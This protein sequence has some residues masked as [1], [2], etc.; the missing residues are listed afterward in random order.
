[1]SDILVQINNI[2]IFD[3]PDA[4]EGLHEGGTDAY[5]VF[6]VNLPRGVYS[7]K[8]KIMM[9]GSRTVRFPDEVRILLKGPLK[10]G[11]LEGAKMIVTCWD[12]DEADADDPMG[13][14]VERLDKD[15]DVRENAPRRTLTG[16]GKFH[17]FE[18]LFNYTLTPWGSGTLV[19]CR[20][21]LPGEGTEEAKNLKVSGQRGLTITRLPW[22]GYTCGAAFASSSPTLSGF[23]EAIVSF[24][25][26]NRDGGRHMYVGIV[27]AS[28]MASV[29]ADAYE[30][31]SVKATASSVTSTKQKAGS[32]PGHVVLLNLYSG[33]CF[34]GTTYHVPSQILS[35][36]LDK[37]SLKELEPE[38]LAGC[39]L[40]RMRVDM[41]ERRVYFAV[42]DRPWVDSGG[43]LGAVCR[44]CAILGD[45]EGTV[46]TLGQSALFTEREKPK[47]EGW[48]KK[49]NLVTA[50]ANLP[51]EQVTKIIL[52]E[53][54][55]EDAPGIAEECLFF[56]VDWLAKKELQEREK[57]R[58]EQEELEMRKA[59]KQGAAAA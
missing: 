59:A 8:T 33:R 12:Y 1:M 58:R 28:D 36:Q 9:D 48:N 21:A 53:V 19:A 57:A 29:A 35:G 27:I 4:D 5:V 6:E 51:A 42:G 44:P 16:I 40:I 43:K 10:L 15:G 31:T 46:V 45:E 32:Q 20:W 22:R 38:Q 47:A 49:Q 3:V 7:G 56:Y 26:T 14:H 55:E 24:R 34:A 39:V 30:M 54:T 13:R 37:D 18:I 41:A 17:S 11:D 25:V 23:D 50:A 2:V 52:D